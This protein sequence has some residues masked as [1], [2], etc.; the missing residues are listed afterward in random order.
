MEPLTIGSLMLLL[1]SGMYILRKKT[2]HEH[3]NTTYKLNPNDTLFSPNSPSNTINTIFGDVVVTATATTA[4][5]YFCCAATGC[6]SL[7]GCMM[8]FNN[9]IRYFAQLILSHASSFD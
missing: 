2:H 1:V 5:V 3:M 4:L 9:R 6:R 7:A 8:R